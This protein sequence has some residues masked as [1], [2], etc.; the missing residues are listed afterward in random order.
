MTKYGMR[1]SE[2]LEA[3]DSLTAQ[4][5]LNKYPELADS[6]DIQNVVGWFHGANLEDLLFSISKTPITKFK[7]TIL[8][9]KGTYDE[10]PKDK[11]RTQRIVKLL[12]NGS[13][14]LP[15]FVEKGDSSMFIMEG[16]HR[17]VAFYDLGFEEVIVAFVEMKPKLN[18]ISRDSFAYAPEET[19]SQY[20]DAFLDARTVTQ[21]HTYDM[22]LGKKNGRFTSG[23][24]DGDQLVSMITFNDIDGRFTI[25]RS[26]TLR[27]YQKQGL[28]KGQ[29]EYLVRDGY[30]PIYSDETQTDSAEE[31]WK[32]L[33][34]NSRGLDFYIYDP[35]DGSKEP[36]TIQNL[37]DGPPWDGSDKIIMMEDNHALEHWIGIIERAN[38]ID[39][40]DGFLRKYP[41]LYGPDSRHNNGLNP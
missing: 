6:N 40:R 23:V 28:V 19:M 5:L 21:I 10:F 36:L 13:P 25:G 22:K 30:G 14:P 1:W 24:F 38:A 39:D 27:S 2:I 9:M 17:I 20:A 15:V 33:I 4:D 3:K 41:A 32:S 26:A 8:E 11:M 31:T 29:L 7:D 16:R 34:R 37:N 18:E 35:E 12:K